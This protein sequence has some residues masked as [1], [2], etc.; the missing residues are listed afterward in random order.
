MACRGPSVLKWSIWHASHRAMSPLA[1]QPIG[2][3]QLISHCFFTPTNASQSSIKSGADLSN[4]FARSLSAYP[5]AY[6]TLSFIRSKLSSFTSRGKCFCST[7]MGLLYSSFITIRRLR[8][9][10][11]PTRRTPKHGR[12]FE[13]I[14]R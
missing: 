11:G 7:L 4:S 2:L 13:T 12:L 14:H 8:M 3:A 10:R 5:M 9:G 1:S 6:I